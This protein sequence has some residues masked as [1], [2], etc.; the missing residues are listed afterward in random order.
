MPARTAHFPNAIIGGIPC[1][2]QEFNHWLCNVFAFVLR[3]FE[4]RLATLKKSI[5]H[6]SE[7]IQLKLVVSS[8]SGPYWR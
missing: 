4:P 1:G 5:G 8:V 7:N 6:L 3:R 2:L